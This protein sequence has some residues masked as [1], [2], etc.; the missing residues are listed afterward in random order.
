MFARQHGSYPHT[1]C[2]FFEKAGAAFNFL[3]HTFPQNASAFRTGFSQQSRKFIAAQAHDHIQPAPG[4]GRNYIRHFYQ[5]LVTGRVSKGV[6][7]LLKFVQVNHTQGQVRMVAL[8]T[9]NL[10][11]EK[12]FKGAAVAN[13]GEGIREQQVHQSFLQG[14][15]LEGT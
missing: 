10:F 5:S 9:L 3:A 13:A 8:V 2:H 12:H 1:D 11:F 6:V 7:V 14:N 4:A 15:A